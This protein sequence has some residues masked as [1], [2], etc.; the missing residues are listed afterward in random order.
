MNMFSKFTTKLFNMSTLY[1]KVHREC[2]KHL[3]NCA[4]LKQFK[5]FQN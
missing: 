5:A 3:P 1:E 2:T 4:I